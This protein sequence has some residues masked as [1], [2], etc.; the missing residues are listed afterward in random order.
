VEGG[1]Y[2]Y[3]PTVVE[4]GVEVDDEDEDEDEDEAEIGPGKEEISFVGHFEDV[5]S[6]A[7]KMAPLRLQ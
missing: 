1:G 7:G 5:R 6:I 3:Q 4:V 2:R